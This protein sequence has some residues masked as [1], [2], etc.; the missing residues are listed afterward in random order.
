[1]WAAEWI[2]T[3]FIHHWRLLR[4]AIESWQKWNSSPHPLNSVHMRQL[5]KLLIHEVWFGLETNY[6]Q[7][8][9]LF[10]F[11]RFSCLNLSDK[12]WHF[13][14]RFVIWFF[15]WLAMWFFVSFRYAI[16][17]RFIV[18]IF[19]ANTF[20]GCFWFWNLSL[21]VL[22]RYCSSNSD[23]NKLYSNPIDLLL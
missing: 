21:L 3:Y 4:V 2:D 5:T 16:F 7:L 17:N 20:H 19:R 8:L 11:G 18:G 9:Q 15:L 1:M 14:P 6:L 22:Y 23:Q 13:P 12:L 10:H